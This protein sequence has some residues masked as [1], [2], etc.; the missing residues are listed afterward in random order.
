MIDEKTLMSTFRDT[1]PLNYAH[2][3]L[4]THLNLVQL[5]IA[6]EL[7]ALIAC[8]LTWT[9]PA[10]STSS[11]TTRIL[12]GRQSGRMQDVLLIQTDSNWFILVQ[13]GYKMFYSFKPIQTGSYWFRQD[14]I[15]FTH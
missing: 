5:F 3:D 9:E 10:E 13:A 12:V 4:R 6:S 11:S 1:S 8:P 2:P 15:C 7:F 14:A